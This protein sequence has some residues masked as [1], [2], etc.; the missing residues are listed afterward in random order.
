MKTTANKKTPTK[1]P[2]RKIYSVVR[3]V[4]PKGKKFR[5]WVID[6]NIGKMKIVRVVTP[7][8]ERLRPSDRIDKIIRA[9]S[10]RLTAKEQKNILRFSVLTPDEY[11][12]ITPRKVLKKAA[13]A[14]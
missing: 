1:F 6:S 5:L 11:S 14:H 9:S 13:L 3:M 10:T 2:R 4:L 12:K 7:A 8:W